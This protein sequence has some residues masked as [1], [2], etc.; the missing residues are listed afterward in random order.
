MLNLPAISRPRPI[1]TDP[2]PVTP[3]DLGMPSQ[4]TSWRASQWDSVQRI[5]NSSKR[6]V[7]I[8]APT[9]FGKSLSAFAAAA[10]GGRTVILTATKG[11][12]DQL[13]EFADVSADIRGLNNYPCPITDRLGIPKD[14]MVSD[15]PCQ[16]G[17]NCGLK[18]GGCG[19]YDLYRQAQLSGI[20]VTNYQ[21]WLYDGAKEHS[22]RGDLQYGLPMTGTAEQIAKS[23]ERQ[24]VRMLIADESHDAAEQLSM[25]LGVDFSRR[26]CLGIKLDWP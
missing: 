17:Y 11:P 18:R 21:C 14:T 25:F 24:K 22:D 10:L 9:G 7:A 6:F 16:C 8:A 12:Q 2:P 19:Y 23:I 26:E 20:V 1:S 4:F 5:I 13:R 3:N 15:A